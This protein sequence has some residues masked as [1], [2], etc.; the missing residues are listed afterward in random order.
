MLLP[1][2]KCM[3]LRL[4]FPVAVLINLQQKELEFVRET[5]T[6]VSGCGGFLL[7]FEIRVKIGFD[8]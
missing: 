2:V 7:S 5:R 8:G 6:R 4:S 3:C 1:E